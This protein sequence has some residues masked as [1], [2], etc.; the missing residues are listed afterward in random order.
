MNRLGKISAPRRLCILAV[1]LFGTGLLYPNS[2]LG[3]QSGLSLSIYRI[4]QGAEYYMGEDIGL[5]GV[6]KNE[7]EWPINTNRGIRELEIEQFLI[8]TDPFG[9]KHVAVQE[10]DAPEDMQPTASWGEWETVPADVLES[11]YIRSVKIKDLG[12]LFPTM[13]EIPGEW[14]IQA[15]VT[16]SRFLYTVTTAEGVSGVLERNT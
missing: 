1:M 5:I 10:G 11:G 15:V 16:I 14:K 6:I 8:A 2:G 7:T 12:T 13:R 3:D 9:I 4:E